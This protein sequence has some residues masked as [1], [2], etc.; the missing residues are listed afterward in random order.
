MPR[1]Y[2]GNRATWNGGDGFGVGYHGG[3]SGGA[4]VHR[5]QKKKLAPRDF[6]DDGWNARPAWERE[7]RIAA[8][9]VREVPRIGKPLSTR[10]LGARIA[11]VMLSGS[12]GPGAPEIIKFLA[13]IAPLHPQARRNHAGAFTNQNGHLSVPWVWVPLDQAARPSPERTPQVAPPR[14]VACHCEDWEMVTCKVACD[15]KAS[16]SR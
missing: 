13:G 9:V 8:A 7:E 10:E 15:Q 3:G 16:T 14:I 12:Q 2:R 4:M 1:E 5:P 6:S 11:G